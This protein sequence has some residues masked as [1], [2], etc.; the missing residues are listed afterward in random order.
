MKQAQQPSLA[1]ESLPLVNRPAA[2]LDIG[3]SEIWVAVP[4]GSE[5][6]PVRCFG[7]FTPDL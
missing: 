3:S 4:P 1:P 6:Q 2:G 5:P 7:T